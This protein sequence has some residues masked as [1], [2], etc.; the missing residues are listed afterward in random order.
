MLSTAV[1]R[2]GDTRARIL[3][4][5]ATAFAANGFRASTI[6]SIAHAARVNEITVYRYFPKKQQLY[7]EAIDTRLRDSGI[8]EFLLEI[9]QSPLDPRQL[10]IEFG[11][12]LIEAVNQDPSLI[13]LLYFAGLELDRERSLLLKTHLLPVINSLKNHIEPRITG[14]T[15]R[16][17]KVECALI[18]FLGVLFAHSSLYRLFGLEPQEPH[19]D[20]QL[21]IEYA[22]FCLAGLEAGFKH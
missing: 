11:T 4:A 21:A 6:R 14:G 5:A 19:T 1:G 18:A 15:H 3:N 16:P 12:R 8:V 17:L 2:S 7:W 20:E 13:R 9:S 22:N 10:F